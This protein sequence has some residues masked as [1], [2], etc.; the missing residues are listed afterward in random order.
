MHE[1][2]IRLATIDDVPRLASTLTDAF[3]HY[4]FTRHTIAADN[5]RS[6]LQRFNELFLGEIGIPHGKVWMAN[7][8]EAAAIWTTPESTGI[9]EA[10]TRL[11]PEFAW[12]AGDRAHCHA[13]AEATMQ[14]YRPSEPVWFL[15]SVGVHP[16][17]QGKG[18]GRAVIQPGLDA[19]KKAGVPAFLET[20]DPGNVRFYE[21]LGF[22]ITAEYDLPDGGPR[23]WSMIRLPD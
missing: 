1:H 23:T 12:L 19:A 21:R 9:F 3:E 18:L 8:G 17:H 4:A 2:Q 13:S 10:F 7:G 5:H 16:A 14:R 15:G 6:R 20:S 22:D 11:E